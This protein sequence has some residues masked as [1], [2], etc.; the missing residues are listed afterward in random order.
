MISSR[1]QKD[2]EIQLP[3]PHGDYL[4]TVGYDHDLAGYYVLL[5][6]RTLNQWNER[7]YEIM[8]A[9]DFED[10]FDLIRVNSL[11]DAIVTALLDNSME[12]KG[13]LPL[14][15]VLIILAIIAAPTSQDI[16]KITDLSKRRH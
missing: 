13:P 9:L 3:S 2:S 5:H 16:Q 4:V 6:Q 7:I 10:P 8:D 1:E 15:D 11:D 14:D 12:S